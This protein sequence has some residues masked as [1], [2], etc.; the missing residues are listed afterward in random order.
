MSQVFSDYIIYVDESG[1][2]S[3]ESIDPGYPVF[4]LAFCIFN[5]ID[6]VNSVTKTI[7]EFKFKYF[8]H[9][10]VLLHEYDIRK[11]K[12]EFVILI[13][14]QIR[15]NFMS[16]LNV[17][18]SNAPFSVIGMVIEKKMLKDKYAD[19]ANPYHLALGFGLERVYSF[20]RERKQTRYKTH[21]VFENRGKKED[22]DLELEFRRVCDGANRWGELPF[23]IIL[24]DKKSNA[25]GLQLADLIARPIGRYVLDEKQ[26][27]RAYSIIE[28]KFY[29]NGDGKIEGW[30][31]KR[32]P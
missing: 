21:I 10:M 2:H 29:C 27:N 23:E 31:L 4:V 25:C 1:D 32:F 17:L 28:N 13:N 14:E 24:A 16:D 12:K 20:L 5:K 9:D 11:A 19:P 7:K 30:G 8:G 6:Y 22:K 15:N 18:I 3:L 26:N